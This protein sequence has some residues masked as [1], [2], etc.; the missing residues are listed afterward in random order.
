MT[1]TPSKPTSINQP[2]AASE[3]KPQQHIREQTLKELEKQLSSCMLTDRFALG[4]RLQQARSVLQQGTPVEHSVR[5][6]SAKIR[7][8]SARLNTRIAA[9]PVPTYP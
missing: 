7:E 5:D 3:Q 2:A 9:L 6:I 8:S 1:S 4:R